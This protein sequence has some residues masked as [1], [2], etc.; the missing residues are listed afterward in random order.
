MELS[1]Q[2]ALSETLGELTRERAFQ[3]VVLRGL[4]HADIGH[5]I[6]VTTSIIPPPAL[7]DVVHTQTEG[8]PL[9]VTVPG[10]M[11]DAPMQRVEN[12]YVFLKN[13]QACGNLDGQTAMVRS[14]L[15]RADAQTIQ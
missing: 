11:V 13:V 1:R 7:V 14:C 5:F 10:C 9:F 8:N 15:G 12:S 3:R 4:S 2:H 6:E